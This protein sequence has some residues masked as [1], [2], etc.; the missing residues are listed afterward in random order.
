MASSSSPFIPWYLLDRRLNG[1]QNQLGLLAKRKTDKMYVQRDS[2]DV[3]S[4]IPTGFTN[5]LLEEVWVVTGGSLVR[6]DM[7]VFALRMIQMTS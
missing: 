2:F 4:A 6:Q 1:P 7:P 5:A 3:L